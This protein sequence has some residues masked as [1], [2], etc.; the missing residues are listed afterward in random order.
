MAVTRPDERPQRR[1]L[2]HPKVEQP[3]F[4]DR[5]DPSRDAKNPTSR[6]GHREEVLLRTWRIA[7]ASNRIPSRI[8]S[9]DCTP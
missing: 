4:V 5:S 1:E 9:C 7:P 3:F 6:P 8:R 2:R